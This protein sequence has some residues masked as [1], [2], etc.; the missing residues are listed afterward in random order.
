[1][2]RYSAQGFGPAVNCWSA[3]PCHRHRMG[4]VTVLGLR[5]RLRSGALIDGAS[6]VVAVWGSPD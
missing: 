6:V 4:V 1:M 5:A 2:G 3:G